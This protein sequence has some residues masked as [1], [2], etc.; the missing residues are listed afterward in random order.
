MSNLSSFK[1][2]FATKPMSLNQDH[3]EGTMS[4][5]EKMHYHYT[6][7]LKC[8]FPRLMA[9]TREFGLTNV[10]TTFTI[11]DIEDHL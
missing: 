6:L 9:P 5:P 3:Q 4:H 2:V 11:Y 7:R 1:N 10:P 8:S